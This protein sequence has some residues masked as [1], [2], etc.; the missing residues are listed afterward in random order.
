[1]VYKGHECLS[2]SHE[3]REIIQRRKSR[4]NDLFPEK[5]CFTG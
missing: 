1:M 3:A 5:G 4:A 2:Q